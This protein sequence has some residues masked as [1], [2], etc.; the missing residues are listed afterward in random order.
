MIWRECCLAIASLML[1]LRFLDAASLH[2]HHHTLG[3]HLVPQATGCPFSRRTDPLTDENLYGS[4]EDLE[5]EVAMRALNW[6]EVKE[7]LVKVMKDSKAWWPADYGHYGPLFIRLAWHAAGSYRF[8]DGRGGA[9]GGRIRFDPERIWGDN[10]NLDKA[11]SLLWPVKQKH[12]KG[13]SW[14]DLIILAGNT[15]IEDMGGT[16]LGFCGGRMDDSTGKAR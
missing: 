12:G 4:K 9:D 11:L 2:H 1:G 6:T 13:L 10:K 15:A 16:V 8:S 3:S 5:V 14:G 7:D